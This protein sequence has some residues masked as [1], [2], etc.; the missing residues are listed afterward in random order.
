[1]FHK[2]QETKRYA[3]QHFKLHFLLMLSDYCNTPVFVYCFRNLRRRT[4]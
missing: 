2:Y 4:N 3:Y 1:M